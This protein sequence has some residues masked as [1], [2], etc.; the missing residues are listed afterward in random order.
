MYKKH[1]LLALFFL[2]CSQLIIAQNVTELSVNISDTRLPAA[3]KVQVF[4]GSKMIAEKN[5]VEG[6]VFFEIG[7][8]TS[9]FSPNE[10]LP[11]L[12][13][14]NPVTDGILNIVVDINILKNGLIRFYDIRGSILGYID[15]NKQS[16][17]I[18]NGTSGVVLFDYQD[19][20]GNTYFGKVVSISPNLKIYI[21]EGHSPE[22]YLKSGLINIAE[23]KEFSVR[24]LNSAGELA[25]QRK[26]TLAIGQHHTENWDAT[27]IYNKVYQKVK[28]VDGNVD[29]ILNRTTE[30][31]S[32]G[33]NANDTWFGGGGSFDKH[34]MVNF[35]EIELASPGDHIKLTLDY[36]PGN[37]TNGLNQ[38]NSTANSIRLGLYNTKGAKLA[39]GIGDAHEEFKTYTGYYGAHSIKM[40]NS[41]GVFRRKTNQPSLIQGNAGDNIGTGTQ[42]SDLKSNERR[43]L[44]MTITRTS[45]GNKVE[46]KQTGSGSFSFEADDSKATDYTYNAIVLGL[47]DTPELIDWLW[48]FDLYVEYTTITHP[49]IYNV[50]VNNGTGGGSFTNGTKIQLESNYAPAGKVFDKWTGDTGFINDVNSPSTF[51]TLNGSDLNISATY[52]TAGNYKLSVNGGAGSGSFSEESKQVIN[53][54]KPPTGKVFDKWTGDTEAMGNVT[55]ANTDVSMP[56]KNITVTATYK[57]GDGRVM[58]PV[59]I[60]G[61]P[62]Y[63]EKV[64]LDLAENGDKAQ[65][66]FVQVHNIS[67]DNK[68]SVRVNG[69]DWINFNNQ[70][71]TIK[72]QTQAKAY[73]GFGGGFSTIKLTIDKSHLTFK[74]GL[75]T[76]EFRYNFRAAPTAGFRVLN[77]NIL[78]AQGSKLIADNVF[79]QDDPTTWEPPLNNATDIA[80]GEAFFKGQDLGI[81][82]NC[83]DC[84]TSTGMDFKY[85]NISNKTI[86]EQVIKSGFTR[87]EGEQVASY[88]RSLN[89]PIVPQARVYNPPYQPGP[90][91]DAKPVYEWAAGAGLEWV[92][93]SDEEMMPYILGSGT[94]AEID[95]V[96]DIKKDLNLREIPVAVMF[97]DW[98]RWIPKTHPMDIWGEDVWENSLSPLKTKKNASEAYLELRSTLDNIGVDNL[99]AQKKLRETVEKFANSVMWWV[100]YDNNTG[101]PWTATIAPMLDK[102][103]PIYS[104]EVA[105]TNLA[106]WM[107]MKLWEVM[108]EYKLQDKAI[109][110]LPTAEKYNWPCNEFAMFVIPAHF[111]GDDRGTSHF[112]WESPVVGAYWSSIWYEVQIIVNSGMREPIG[113]S[114]SD[115]AY[116]FFH[117]NRIGE[118]SGI[119]EPLRM[120]RNLIKC[121]QQRDQPESRGIQDKTWTLREVSPWRAY[122]SYDG[123]QR[124][125]EKM[126]EYKP[127]LRASFTSS[128]Y[129]QFLEKSNKF[130]LSQWPRTNI[131]GYDS[132]YWYKLEYAN[133]DPTDKENPDNGQGKLFA[134]DDSFDA[135]EAHA[136][137]RLLDGRN[138]PN[139]L[140]QI[141][142][143]DVVIRGLAD[144]ADKMWTNPNTNWFTWDK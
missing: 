43:T 128:L 41:P 44:N 50:A 116:N 131:I 10:K 31:C 68:G 4:D 141:G 39:S 99:I 32:L 77:T 35:D 64:E 57:D 121:Y 118:R 127:G 23:E 24:Y 78:N 82:A 60:M 3:G 63:T 123:D 58:L 113:V 18:I 133:Y 1:W 8:T 36:R 46:Y 112:A 30:D 29:F 55:A 14:P 96:T 93:E 45:N 92:L 130:S 85:F 37:G 22:G 16:Q 52:R 61:L 126:N 26:L 97:P 2:L 139:R 72:M 86:T 75:N 19:K 76:V 69:G 62:P 11:I 81:G 40:S 17:C 7:N 66:L 25:I 56:Q 12:V 103:K 33:G 20:A 138:G 73:G 70:S 115:W 88:I 65:S 132:D 117:L 136:F 102:R 140:Q 51:L 15:V 124:L 95:A 48:I 80:A 110:E 71:D 122:S 67:Y 9:V 83:K 125:M 119:F 135:I 137:Y 59:E 91:T 87:K 114:P 142:V 104:A 34:L 105:K 98:L 74:D 47:D 53:A 84:H 129:T 134:P 109:L 42:T 6:S 106:T 100:G 79:Y 13:Y 111:T 28:G 38:S 49:V 54:Q 107:T 101:H 27:K 90:G 5:L 120:T 144:W 143:D 94:R 89:M 108:M 21:S